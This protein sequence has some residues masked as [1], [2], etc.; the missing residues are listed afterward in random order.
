MNLSP[1]AQASLNKVVTK[2]QSGDLSSIVNVAAMKFHRS[3]PVP[4][5]AWSFS[6]RVL[7]YIQTDST[8]CR[9]FKQ[10]KKAGRWVKKGE[11]AAY[12]LVPRTIKKTTER[13]G[14]KEE[15]R[16]I[17]GF[18]TAAV[19]ADTQTEGDTPLPD[20]D[21]MPKE[22]PPL[23]DVAKRLGIKVNYTITP[24][25]RLG[26]CDSEGQNINIGTDDVKTFF[27]E[28]AHA[29]HARINGGTLKGNDT[30]K[31][32][33]VAEFTATV[34]MEMYGY[35]DRSGNC[36]RYIQM[37]ANDPI[38]AVTKALADIEKVLDLLLTA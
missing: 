7:A 5:D 23:S 31:L 25:D 19:F 17:A 32:E 37:Y 3:E 29:A 15:F 30:V 12:I 26:D 9:G 1:K 4:F 21:L 6:N 36:W 34:L 35:G 33:T 8:D 13:D 20:S 18:L 24:P 14:E 11:R 28:I 27:H 22:L 10:W 2:F 16:V 38:T